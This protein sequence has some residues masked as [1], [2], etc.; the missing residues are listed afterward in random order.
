MLE[1][2]DAEDGEG[3]TAAQSGSLTHVGVAAFHLK[4]GTKSEKEKAAW[5]AIASARAKFPLAEESEVRLFITPYMNDPRNLLA[6][7]AEIG[8]KP[9]IEQQVEFTLPPHHLDT[10]GELI[11]IQGTYDQIRIDTDGRPYVADLKTGKPTVLAMMHDYAVQ[12]G[13]YT[14]GAK[15]WFDS[16]KPG[17]IIRAYSY[18]ERNAILPSPDNVFIS[19]PYRNMSQIDILLEGVR[20]AVAMVRNGEINLTPGSQCSYCEFGGLVGCLRALDL[21]ANGE[22][23]NSPLLKLSLPR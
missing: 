2:I 3:G 11:Y 6:R 23:G 15:R 9:C 12:L 22:P 17:K 18:R 14:Y 1:Y 7:F 16:I 21:I 13:A 8:G 5:D 19:T 4:H 10:T 20:F